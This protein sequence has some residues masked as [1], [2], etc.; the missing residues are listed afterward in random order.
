MLPYAGVSADVIWAEFVHIC[1]IAPP[2]VQHLA[3]GLVESYLVH[4]CP[5]LK[6]VWVLLDGIS[7]FCY[8]TCT[9]SLVS[10]ASC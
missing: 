6:P 3:L 9:H 2:Q 5:D 10:S 1:E 4:G 8:V 7:S